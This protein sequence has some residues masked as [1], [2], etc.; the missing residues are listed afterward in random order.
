VAASAIVVPFAGLE[1]TVGRWRRALTA[2]GAQSMPT[3]VTLIYPFVPRTQ[4]RDHLIA[5]LREVLATFSPFDVRFEAFARFDADPPVLYLQPDPAQP[6]LE[7]IAA[8]A[9]RF[10][11]HPP[12]AGIHDPIIPHLT[13][14][15]TRDASAMRAAE[16]SV[17]RH[18]PLTAAAHSVHIMEHRPAD[19]WR[20]HTAI[21]L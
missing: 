7:L 1:P 2:D 18:L 16:E 3:H 5:A 13:V 14:A 21:A 20:T 6:F 12:F 11:D 4:L 8:I 15:Q 19:G 9:A 10:P 17:A